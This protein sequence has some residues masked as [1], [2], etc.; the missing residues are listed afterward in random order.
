MPRISRRNF[1]GALAFASACRSVA[2]EGL[3]QSSRA[4]ASPRFGFADV[5]ARA[6]D[7]AAA[8]F[9]AAV[10]PLP[11]SIDH[12]E[13]DSWRDIRFKRDAAVP[14]STGRAFR[15]ETFHLGFLF[16]RAIRVNLI[17]NGVA[18]PL[19][20]SPKFFDY[21]RV[22]LDA[23]LPADTGFAGFR[24]HYPLNDPHVYDEVISFIGASYFRFLGR[25]Q[26]YGLSARA[27]CVEA[28]T[29]KESFPLF[30][31]FWLEAS[32]TQD[33]QATIY[34][35]LDS[36]AATGAFRFDL[37]PGQDTVVDVEATL[38]PR[39]AGVKFG[40]AP[41]TSMF[42]TG[43]NDHRV[44]DGFR[45]ELHDSDG[46]LMLTGANEWIWRPLANPPFERMT[47][48]LDNGVKG[49]G[50]LQRDRTFESYQDL[51]LGY[52]SR[53]SYFIEP[54]GDWGAGRI[55]LVEL[56]TPDET[57]DNIVASFVPATPLTVGQPFSYAYRITACLDD[58]RLSPNGRC[59]NTFMAPARALGSS[60]KAGPGT[61]R[62]MV[63]FSGGDLAY[64]LA[65]PSEVKVVATAANGEILR[66][67]VAANPHID[68]FRAML[69][70]NVT[71]GQTS[72]LRAYLRV[73]SRSLTETWTFP[74]T[75][76]VAQA[77]A[78]ASRVQKTEEQKTDLHASVSTRAAV[79][80]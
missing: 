7:L 24:L 14:L 1:M 43:E 2:A 28:G 56:S 69:D 12:L 29:E 34:A 27:L 59:V 22:K 36:E 8:A 3:G 60:E 52:E 62:F 23:S 50:L 53:P 80:N 75:A 67:S 5:T 26:K 72:D 79:R 54:K 68:G 40:L 18:S 65:D 11:Q 9:D 6:R 32:A 48:F 45:G 78:E 41:L 46:L 76:P 38:F 44:R 13:Y 15:L 51:E 37:T 20:Y 30:R 77:H 63:D 70:I 39:R 10:P 64:Y 57:N 71:P 21:G 74:W 49:F 16:K 58:A 31:E 47:S 35:L 33:D 66:A 19:R 73:G 61:C 25:G 4:V 55:E 42:L 17:E